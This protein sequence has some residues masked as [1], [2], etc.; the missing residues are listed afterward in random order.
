MTES[1]A[2]QKLADDIAKTPVILFV[3]GDRE[4][5][6]C[7]FSKAVMDIFE[8]IGV[9][10]ETRDV[11]S[12]PEIRDGIKKL[13]NWPTIPQVFLNGEFIGGC[14]I[15]RDLFAKGELETMVKA[16]VAKK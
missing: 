9:P 4:E 14:D 11:L 6:M 1:N 12:D 7:G 5:P 13:T 2:Q 15:V 3:K 10:F 8:Q 16:A